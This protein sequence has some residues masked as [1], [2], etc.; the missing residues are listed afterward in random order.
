MTGST[1]RSDIQKLARLIKGIRVAMLTTRDDDGTLRSRPMGTQEVEFDGTLWFFTDR[2]SPKV[3]EIDQEDEV[4]VSYA[5]T[6]SNRFVSVSGLA[7][8]VTDRRKME[9]LWTPAMR[10]WFPDGFDDPRIGLLRVN[11]TK[12]EYWERPGSAVVG[13]VGFVKAAATGRRYEPG[14]NEKLD[15]R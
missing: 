1:D 9:E 7:T 5:D 11:V 3:A 2:Q 12:A 10:A 15:L 14:R 4:N 13:L 6:D 8:L